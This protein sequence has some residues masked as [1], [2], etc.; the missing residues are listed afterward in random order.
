MVINRGALKATDHERGA[1]AI[2][3]FVP[4]ELNRG[5]SE[6]AVREPMMNQSVVTIS[7]LIRAPYCVITANK[8]WR[9]RHIPEKVKVITGN[10]L[11]WYIP[12]FLEKRGTARGK[13]KSD[14]L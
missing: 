6:G 3:G 10:E 9:P 13:A 12:G 2:R 14:L 7:V 11:C 8:L 1:G 4:C 5:D